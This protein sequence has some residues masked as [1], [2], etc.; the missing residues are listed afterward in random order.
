MKTP[1][2]ASFFYFLALFALG[3]V[4]GTLRVVFVAPQIGE[5]F[6][7]SLELPLMLGAS[8]VICLRLLRQATFLLTRKNLW[9]FGGSAFAYLMIAEWW[10]AVSIIKISMGAYFTHFATWPGMIGL[11]GQ[12][13][14]GLLPRLSWKHT[15]KMDEDYRG[16]R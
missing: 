4:L 1:W 5:L 14:F 6:A 8:W 3:F 11:A 2:T 10:V 9:I 15:L 12:I 16:I 13:V 7:I